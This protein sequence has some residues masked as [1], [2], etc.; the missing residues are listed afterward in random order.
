MDWTEIPQRPGEP[1]FNNLL[2]VL[3]REIPSRPT[4]FE[5]FLNDRLHARL[6]PEL[7]SAL[8][9]GHTRSPQDNLQFRIQAYYRAGYD[10]TTVLIPDF[11]FSNGLIKRHR[12]RSVSM[13]EGAVLHTR[14]DLQAFTWPDP[15]AADY[16]ILRRLAAML[17]A[18]MKLIIYT[19]NGVLEN[20]VDLVGYE[21]LCM[22]IHDDA[23]LASDIFAEVGTRLVRYYERAL[24]YDIVGAC[25]SNDDWGHKTQ[26]MFSPRDMRKFVFPW[27]KRIVETIHAANRPVILHSCGHFQR[28]INDV[29][30]DMQY[31][32]RHSYEDNIMPVEEF[33]EGYHQRIGVL[34]GIDLDFVCRSTPEEVYQRSRAMLERAATRGGYALG[35]G[36]SIPDYVPDSNYF[37]MIRAALEQR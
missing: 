13:N 25:I 3:R 17:P 34:G 4:L 16:D 32:G 2:A 27:H 9:A 8:P 12:D 1:D 7:A 33:Y 35:T 11:D 26:T 37:A 10:Y 15:E 5:F 18:G 29:I 23:Q 22:L 14:A 31:D 6:A 21:A 30:D 20:V 28:I 36:N 19:P 24:A